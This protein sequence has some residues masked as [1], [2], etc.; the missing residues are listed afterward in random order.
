MV[1]Y[2]TATGIDD[3]LLINF[4]ASAEVKRKYRTYRPTVDR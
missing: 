2:L 3:G 4:G 1:H